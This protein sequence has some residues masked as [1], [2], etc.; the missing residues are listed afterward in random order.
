M[1]AGALAHPATL[2][3]LERTRLGLVAPDQARALK[4]GEVG[5][6]GRR[7]GQPN[8]LAYLSNR[9]RIAMCV[10]VGVD[11]LEDLALSWG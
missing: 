6:N 5:V 11:E 7:R 8:R 2:Y 10:N 4:P 9:R 1:R 3:H